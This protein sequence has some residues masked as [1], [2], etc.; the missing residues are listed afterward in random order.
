MWYYE[1]KRNKLKSLLSRFNYTILEISWKREAN[2][3]KRLF[4]TG[5][6]RDYEQAGPA[7]RAG[8]EES[9]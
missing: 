6:R 3:K 1:A 2:F 5:S 7:G 8:A 9:S 4:V